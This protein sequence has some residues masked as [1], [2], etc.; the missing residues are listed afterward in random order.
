MPYLSMVY[1]ALREWERAEDLF[2]FEARMK[3]RGDDLPGALE[4]RQNLAEI[5]VIQ[6]RLAEAEELQL[7]ILE[8]RKST[9]LGEEHLHTLQGS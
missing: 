5:Y 4:C 9:L 6:D 3:I 7:Q 1:M 8:A 2:K